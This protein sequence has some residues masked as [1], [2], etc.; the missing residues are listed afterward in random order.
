MQALHRKLQ[1]SM[2]IAHWV[3]HMAQ[4]ASPISSSL[5]KLKT[6]F[7]PQCILSEKHI[8]SH[9]LKFLHPENQSSVKARSRAGVVH[10]DL[11]RLVG[12]TGLWIQWG[13]DGL[14]VAVL[15]TVWSLQAAGRVAEV[16]GRPVVRGQAWLRSLLGILHGGP[17]QILSH[18]GCLTWT[19]VHRL[20]LLLVLAGLLALLLVGLFDIAVMCTRKI[21]T[22]QQLW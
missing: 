8:T 6:R 17:V 13:S 16:G 7:S 10:A 11:V 9:S 15:G 21:G 3:H 19:V 18:S 20:T 4:S 22:K 12:N 2:Y 5:F 1:Q 14:A